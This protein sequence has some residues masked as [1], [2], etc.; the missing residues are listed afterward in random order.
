MSEVKQDILA[1]RLDDA[2]QQIDK[3]IRQLLDAR[4]QI[5]KLKEDL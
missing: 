5:I 4:E 2:L 1:I 3:T